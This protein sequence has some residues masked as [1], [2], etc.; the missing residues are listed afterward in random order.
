M[1]AQFKT[2]VMK[3]HFEMYCWYGQRIIIKIEV[4]L[5]LILKV[6]FSKRMRI[7]ENCKENKADNF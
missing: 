1:I 4:R 3:K 5:L 6:S 2:N 7:L